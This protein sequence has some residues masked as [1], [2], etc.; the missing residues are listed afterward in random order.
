MVSLPPIT[1]P[2]TGQCPL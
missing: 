2:T 1:D